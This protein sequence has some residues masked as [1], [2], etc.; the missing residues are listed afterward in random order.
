MIRY[1]F[2]D[3]RLR[4][5]LGG[6]D[7]RNARSIR[8]HERLGFRLHYHPKDVAAVLVNPLIAYRVRPFEEREREVT[9]ALGTMVIDWWHNEV[10]EAALHLVAEEIETG[11]LVGHL[12]GRDRSVPEPSHRPGQFH[13]ALDVAPD[14]RRKGIGGC[15]Y[16]RVERFA[17]ERNAQLLYVA[18]HETPDAPPAAAFLQRRGFTPL[19]RFLPSSC[20]LDTFDPSEFA[21]AIV[22]VEQQ[23]IALTTYAELEDSAERRQQLYALEEAAHAAQPFREIEPYVAAPYSKW[24]A[25]F[26]RRDPTTI[27]LAL[28]PGSGE[29][30]GV[31]TALEW[32]FTGTNPDWCGRGIA[33]ALKVRCMEEAKRRGI[34]VIETENHEDNAAMLAINRKLGFVIAAPEVACIK[35]L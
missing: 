23:G 16:D 34:E 19:E 3:L 13:F 11:K 27:F 7:I 22:R 8:L 29:I 6:A 15:L 33:T 18:Y 2:C 24:E 4:R 5:L 17:R 30:V 21:A 35:R 10:P 12:Q 20:A 14:H 9:G 1:A 31:V 26:L 32:C 25:K 28:A